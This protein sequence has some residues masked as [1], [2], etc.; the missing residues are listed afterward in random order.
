[1]TSPRED[2]RTAILVKERYA[3]VFLGH[4][5]VDE[6]L[7]FESK[8]FRGWLGEIRRRAFDV[9]L[10]IHDTP[11]S[12]LW[13]AF[14]GA[15]RRLRYDKRAW[16]RRRLVW[17]KKESSALSGSVADRYLEALKPLGISPARR[18]P[19]LRVHEAADLPAEWKRRLGEGPLVGVAPGAAHATKRWPAERFAEAADALA[20]DLS[21]RVLIL[22]AASDEAAARGVL[23]RLR[24]P[25]LN[26]AGKTS[27]R[28]LLL[29]VRRCSVLLT[30]DSGAMH[31]AAAQA[32]PV[33][34][35]F[36]PTV[37]AF[38]FFPAGDRARALEVSGL[39]CRPCRLHGGSRC[40]EGHFRCMRDI[41]A[42]RVTEAARELLSG[43][44]AP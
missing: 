9:Y 34:A 26:F 12:R 33:A 21:A 10:D 2:R 7:T 19:S 39:S 27:V 31:A 24:S 36:G 18:E 25:A 40:P 16:P 20:R 8:G 37:R 29:L 11:R 32:V 4:P 3:D 28:E 14:S 13:G 30:N 38:G 41:P 22:G 5:A 23:E 42:A 6:V 35:V 43:K 1:M 15:A 44:A 17:F